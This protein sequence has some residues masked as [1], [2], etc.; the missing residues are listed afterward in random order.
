MLVRRLRERLC[1]G[2][3][4]IEVQSGLL[5]VGPP[6]TSAMSRSQETPEHD[7]RRKLNLSEHQ[8][9]PFLHLEI[10]HE[11]DRPR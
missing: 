10:D 5:L 2:V 4:V 3:W 9:Y 11:P 7:N 8:L 1:I 6:R